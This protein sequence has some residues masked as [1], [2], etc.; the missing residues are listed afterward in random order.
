MD[1]RANPLM[2]PKVVAVVFLGM[3]AMVA[4]ITYLIHDCWM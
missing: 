3:A 2:D 4:V 1:G